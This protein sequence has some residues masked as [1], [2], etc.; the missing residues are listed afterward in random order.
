[1]RLVLVT[2]STLALAGCAST[3]GLE[4]EIRAAEARIAALEAQIDADTAPIAQTTTGL[5]AHVSYAPLTRWADGF[6]ARPADERTI[7]FQQ[8]GHTGY[9]LRVSHRC[10]LGNTRAGQEAQFSNH[11]VTRA[12][13][14]VRQ[15]A[16]E[17]QP[18]G[19]ILRAPLE[20]TGETTVSARYR[21]PCLNW[22]GFPPVGIR[23]ET[24]PNAAFQLRLRQLAGDELDY[25]V[26]LVSPQTI[27]LELATDVG[28]FT[29]RMT[30][31]IKDVAA[32]LAEGKLPLFFDT[33]GSVSLPDGQ[34]LGYRLATQGPQVSTQPT[35]IEVQTD[36]VV[37]IDQ[38]ALRAAL[39][40][41]PR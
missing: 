15:L 25:T 23:A 40:A 41:P 17:A 5:R 26:D 10:S 8:T 27:N 20:V 31:P 6:N 22:N 37:E 29:V 21:P 34:T 28:P 18:D 35:G 24:R 2:A 19:L 11:N 32:R 30:M 4:G 36:F 14:V 7:R 38:A 13:V 12:A 1:M 3:G 9:L 39:A 16:T 33:D